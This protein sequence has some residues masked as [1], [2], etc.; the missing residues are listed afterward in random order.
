MEL[1]GRPAGRRKTKVVVARR[2]HCTGY[3]AY[4][5]R[6]RRRVAVQCSLSGPIPRF[7]PY[8]VCVRII[9]AV[10]IPPHIDAHSLGMYLVG[11]RRLQ[12]NVTKIAHPVS[13]YEN[14]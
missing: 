2:V 10:I 3:G 5:V 7:L 4:S 9:L 11:E 8:D 1:V 12:K 14:S 13:R 6:R